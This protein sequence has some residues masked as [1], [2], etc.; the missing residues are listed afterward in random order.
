MRITNLHMPYHMK[1]CVPKQ[2]IT[3][4]WAIIKHVNESIKIKK[5]YTYARNFPIESTVTCLRH[6]YT[7]A[8]LRIEI[9]AEIYSYT[10]IMKLYLCIHH[11][12]CFS[13]TINFLFHVTLIF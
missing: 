11:L 1:K 6:H 9:E 7:S 8:C 12:C 10:F 13:E 3:L 4:P 5:L 2:M